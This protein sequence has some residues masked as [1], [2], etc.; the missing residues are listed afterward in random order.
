MDRVSKDAVGF[1]FGISID[2][3]YE[4]LKIEFHHEIHFVLSS[5]L[6]LVSFPTLSHPIISSVSQTYSRLPTIGQ[7]IQRID[8]IP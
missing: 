1:V 2:R 4:N 8:S 5:S 3:G 6:S 7:V